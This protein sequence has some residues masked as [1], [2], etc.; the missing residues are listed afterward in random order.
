L[1]KLESL[2]SVSLAEKRGS[3]EGFWAPVRGGR[4]H[5]LDLRKMQAQ[6]N[7]LARCQ[8]FLKSLRSI[9]RRQVNSDVEQA[10]VLL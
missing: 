8:Y 3:M 1:G 7:H 2:P 4:V 10:Y 5:L 9:W 6:T